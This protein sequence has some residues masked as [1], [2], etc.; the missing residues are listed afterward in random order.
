MLV[1]L[2]SSLFSR[3]ASDGRVL[4][5]QTV[6]WASSN[7]MYSVPVNSLSVISVTLVAAPGEARRKS[8]CSNALSRTSVASG[9][10]LLGHDRSFVDAVHSTTSQ[11]YSN[12]VGG[13]CDL[14]GMRVPSMLYGGTK[15]DR[16]KDALCASL[17]GSSLS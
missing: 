17:K 8:K 5:D 16:Q 6:S 13:P 12:P 10:R 15:F 9:L 4:S 1:G 7:S 2:L 3:H 11:V 14:E